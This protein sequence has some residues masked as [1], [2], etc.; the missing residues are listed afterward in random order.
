MRGSS[1]ESSKSRRHRFIRHR[2]SA[3]VNVSNLLALVVLALAASA[4]WQLHRTGLDLTDPHALKGYVLSL[5]MWEPLAYVFLLAVTVVVS[6][7]PGVPLAVAAGMVWGSLLGGAYTIAGGFLGSLIAYY[8]GRTL[9]RSAMLSLT[10]KVVTFSHARGERSLGIIIFI[11]RLLPVVPFDIV[12]Y[13]SSVTGLRLPLYAVATLL[14]MTPSV[15]LLTY[16]GSSLSMSPALALGLSGVAALSLLIF[17]RLIS[18][19]NWLGLR[20]VIQVER[21]KKGYK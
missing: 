13:A 1:Y 5:G 19:N 11:S 3:L 20:D 15:L 8:L 12:S 10:G 17:P 2:L 14:G 9:G 7:L 16:L 18:R 21:E 6:Q 4:T